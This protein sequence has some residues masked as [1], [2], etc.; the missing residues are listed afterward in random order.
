MKSTVTD[1]SAGE[2]RRGRAMLAGCFLLYAVSGCLDTLKGAALSPLLAE[3][4]FSYSLGGG[5][6]TAF[7]FGYLAA[8]FL[9]GLLSSRLDKRALPL[10]SALALGLG[11]L[12]TLGARNPPAFLAAS[13]LIGI[14]GGINQT[15]CTHIVIDLRP[16]RPGR[17]LNLLGATFGL[18]SML[19]PYCFSQLLKTGASWRE[20]YRYGL[21]G[22]A[23]AFAYFLF[24]GYPKGGSAP[25]VRVTLRDLAALIPARRMRWFYVLIFAYVASEVGICAWL[26]EYLDKVRGIPIDLGA[27]YLSL[28]YGGMLAGRCLGSLFVDRLG[29]RRSLSLA[30]TASLFCVTAGVFGP[31]SLAFLLPLS[32]LFY[33]IILPTATAILTGRGQSGPGAE[34]GVFFAFVGLGGMAGPWLAGAVNDIFGLEFGLWVAAAFC[35]LQFVSIRR[36]GRDPGG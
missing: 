31:G 32:G 16:R 10:A 1:I 21:A 26:I 7:Y 11:T 14:G 17:Y 6:M 2:E 35:L 9:A 3:T 19:T 4:G 29:L 12:A 27:S 33:S 28:F 8:A 25:S 36:L 30:G 13:L 18:V 15:G 34:L 23:L 5:L 20:A 24:P 22:A